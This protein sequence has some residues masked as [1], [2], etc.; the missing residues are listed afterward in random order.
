MNQSPSTT[1]V[2]AS[3]PLREAIRAAVE[4]VRANFS[5]AKMCDSTLA[6]YRELDAAAR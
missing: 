6:L 5:V 3:S 2:P 4:S 1:T